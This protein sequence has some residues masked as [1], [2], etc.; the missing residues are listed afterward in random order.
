MKVQQR[1]LFEDDEPVVYS[2][3]QI[4]QSLR[5]VVNQS[6]GELVV[7]GELSNTRQPASGHW[8]LT[9]K[10]EKAQLGA[11]FFRK[12]AASLGFLP[13]DGLRVRAVGELDVYA[14]QGRYQLVVRRLEP[15]GQG[16][17]ELAFRQ[18]CDRLRAEGLFAAERKKPLPRI[19]QRIALVTSGTGAAVRDML[20]TLSRR[21]PVAAVSVVSVAVQGNAAPREIVQALEFLNRHQSVE[22]IIVGRGGG[23]LEDL[24]A[25]NDE[26]VARAIVASTIPI[27]A[28][29]GHEVDTTIADLVA[30]QRAATPTAA[31]ALVVPDQREVRQWLRSSQ[32]RLAVALR[33]QSELQTERLQTLRR[34]YGLQRPR[35]LINDFR[36][37]LDDA[38]SELIRNMQ[39][40]LELRRRS[41]DGQ[42]AKLQALSPRGVLERGYSYCVDEESGQVVALAAK[43]GEQQNVRLHFADGSVRGQLM[44]QLETMPPQQK[45]K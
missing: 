28:G 41:C 27:V 11:V 32:Q 2:V 35:R 8:Y 19:P 3:S 1:D 10:D 25:F 23:S 16:S 14:P 15:V 36:Q 21:W 7:E 20:T 29:V 38:S 9:L 42:S 31:A 30:D 40:T 45:G 5:S 22:V 37:Q 4:T 26:T 33:R 24:W 12:D 44:G 43:T 39:T 17:L 34:S 13:E 6:F 18:L